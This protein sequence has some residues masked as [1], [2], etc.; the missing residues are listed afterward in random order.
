MLLLPLTAGFALHAAFG[1]A[2]G[3]RDALATGKH[4]IAFRLVVAETKT[5][6]NTVVTGPFGIVNPFGAVTG[7][8]LRRLAPHR[9]IGVTDQ[10]CGSAERQ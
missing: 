6:R 9:L 1:I 4:G 7:L 5:G 2:D 3:I 10:I 8:Q